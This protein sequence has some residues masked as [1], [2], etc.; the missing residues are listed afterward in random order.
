MKYNLKLTQNLQRTSGGYAPLRFYISG[1]G[2][3]DYIPIELNWKI[4]DFDEQSGTIARGNAS[5]N[6]YSK[7]LS[8]ISDLQGRITKII[9]KQ[10]FLSIKSLKVDLK[11]DKFSNDFN[12]YARKKALERLKNKEISSSTYET[13]LDAL[14]VVK[15]FSPILPFTSINLTW[16]ESYKSFLINTKKYERNTLWARLKDLRTYLGK[17]KKD[18]IEFEYPF[19][20]NFKM[21]K[22]EPRIEFLYEDEF[23]S[24]KEHYLSKEISKA[25]KTVLRAFLFSCYTALRISDIQNLMGKHIKKGLIEFE[26]QKSL[27]SETKAIKKLRIPL[28]PFTKTLIGEVK[29]EEFVFYD[30]PTEQKINE[31]LKLIAT[32]LKIEKDITFHYARHTFGTRF[33]AAGGAL[34]ILQEIMG[35]EDIKTTM[36]YVHIEPSRKAKQ[37]NLLS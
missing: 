23:N 4:E 13:Q 26:P 8:K 30:L 14:N 37:I 2:Q 33:M 5:V 20:S 7:A 16:L 24:I 32:K 25:E 17:A 1:E 6:E 12:E 34:E 21:P 29:K 10:A 9:E 19:G 31:R 27:N 22:S 36:I 18:K 35:H 3:H 28:H 11:G 15:E